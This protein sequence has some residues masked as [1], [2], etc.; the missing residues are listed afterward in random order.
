MLSRFL[1]SL[2]H[3]TVY[4]VGILVL[5][6]AVTVTLIRLALPDIGIY[7][8]EIEGWVSR[9]MGYPVV[10]HSLDANWQGWIPELTLRNIDLLNKAGDQTITHFDK[11]KVRIAPLA[12]LRQRQF[13]PKSLIISGFELSIS[14]LENG[15]ISIQDIELKGPPA[16]TDT[17]T[18]ELAEW[19]FKQDEIEIQ[20]ATIEWTDRKNQQ[21][22]IMLSNVS[23][24]LRN[25]VGR[26]QAD[27]STTL[28]PEYGST[29]DFAFEAFGDLLTSNWSAELY[30]SGS[31]INPDHWYKKYR[32]VNL[33]ITGGNADIEVWST[34]KQARVTKLEGGLKYVDFEAS[35]GNESIKV[36]ELA[37]R[38][39]G[40][41]NNQDGWSFHVDLSNLLTENGLW[42]NTNISIQAEPSV[43]DD[44]YRY[45]TSFDYLKMDDLS[46]L[47]SNLVFL[48]GQAKKLIEK[49]SIEGELKN[50]HLTYDPS[51]EDGK[52][53]AYDTEFENLSANFGE[54]NPAFSRLNGHIR[55]TLTG[56]D[57]T[58]TDQDTEFS[59]P[60]IYKQNIP[61]SKISGTLNWSREHSD[62]MLAS[63]LLQIETP[64]FS[65]ELRGSFY[66]D[67]SATTPFLD[68]IVNLGETDVEKIAHYLPVTP[69]FKLK[70]WLERAVLGGKLES[71]SAL[72][73]GYLNEFPFDNNNGRFELIADVTNGTLEYSNKWPLVDK[74]DT[75]II[76]QGRQMQAKIRNG[77]I[78][79]ADIKTVTASMEDILQKKKSVALTGRVDG[80]TRDL[81]LFIDQS[82][83]KNNLPLNEVKKSME[84][85]HFGLEL[86]LFIPI[87]QKGKKTKI[88]G[89]IE[90]VDVVMAPPSMQKIQIHKLNGGISFTRESV[91]SDVLTAEYKSKP[92]SI[93]ASGSKS[94][95][96]NPLH[97]TMAGAGNNTFIVDRMI[98]YIPVVA[99]FKEQLSERITGETNWN[100]K[101][102]Y[103]ENKEQRQLNK[104]IEISSDLK[105][106]D[107]NLPVPLRKT[108]NTD[109]PIKITTHLSADRNQS[110]DISHGSTL[111]AQLQLDKQTKP[112]LQQVRIYNDVVP[113]LTPVD[114]KLFINGI[115][116]SLSVQEWIDVIKMVTGDRE[117]SHPLFNDIG[118]DLHLAR[119][120]IF[121]Q[122]YT[123]VKT[124]ATRT[125]AGWFFNLDSYGIRGDIILPK[126]IDRSSRID[127]QLTE[128]HFDKPSTGSTE[129]NKFDPLNLPSFSVDVDKF[130]YHGREM[131]ELQLQTST[132]T[133][134]ISVDGFEFNKPDLNIKG[135]GKWL[136]ESGTES[137]RFNIDLHADYLD[138]MLDTFGYELAPINKGKTDLKIDAG[139]LGA[140]MDFSLSNLNGTLDMKIKKGQLLD[141]NPAAAGRLFGL[142]S[143]QA[144]PRR[145]SLDF[146][147][148]F[149]K[150]LSFDK[151]EG[152]FDITN[153]N[154]YTNNL[155]MNS[156]AAEVAISG[157][158]G[159]AA[160]DYD[161]IVT[162][163]PQIS[164][165][166]PIA[167]ALFG[168]VG[169]GI[170]AL[171][172]LA[173]EMF[174]SEKKNTDT[175]MSYQYTIT[176]SWKNPV[177]QKVKEKGVVAGS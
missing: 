157:R 119:L 70:L 164:G 67:Q 131:G 128:L 49:F 69:K 113:D 109:T 52:Q 112:K 23:L 44:S 104:L 48:P 90:L 152:S 28:P 5:F 166:L 34:W 76:F 81:K 82:P 83:L 59:L 136:V 126:K 155:Y 177:V 73:R 54:K 62:W 20:D 143:I 14:Y 167:G 96:N 101:L 100:V 29:M 111:F 116:D 115:L 33:N 158:T 74:L 15:S 108:G 95:E 71:A 171:I 102:T 97:I 8:S 168:P 121:N 125:A 170:G 94:D 172:Y 50:V 85:G 9:Y 65:A 10:I 80:E 4:A 40:E 31:N 129:D 25:D 161:Q 135:N 30:L 103:I 51:Q 150:G 175:M 11:A 7:R 19:L 63:E 93:T 117:T 75:E 169:I 41:R 84:S 13:I 154:A 105:G 153:G 147:D 176:G 146:S 24:S 26:L 46:P 12:T 16:G 18:N 140:P 27:G 163:M 60:S 162:V 3:F 159:L 165:S 79:N 110:I 72:F 122:H 64:D 37:Y 92:V 106:L 35:A 123:D 53:F 78:F 120:N 160:H 43:K 141:V 114:H 77:K 21:P 91:H 124:L 66:K 173:D 17:G 107:I 149:G 118:I 137:S 88:A 36:K 89:N 38:F 61:F 156:P 39:Y 1:K 2:Y 55:G 138:A 134:G 133:N 87:K 32:P 174:S 99:N 58:L 144:L 47:L 57:I 139:W 6:T 151:I 86:D 45:I 98:E 68:L 132:I 145:L 127:L 148:L 42:P 22:P 142:L 56:G 130:V